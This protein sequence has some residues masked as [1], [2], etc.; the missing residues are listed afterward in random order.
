MRVSQ[1]DV[2]WT[3][4]HCKKF[5]NKAIDFQSGVKPRETSA[6]L[7]NH[8]IYLYNLFSFTRVASKKILIKKI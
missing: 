7:E 2:F 1:N 6:Y 4:G 3:D 5:G 8:Y